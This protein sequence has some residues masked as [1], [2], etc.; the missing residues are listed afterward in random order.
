MILFPFLLLLSSMHTISGQDDDDLDN[1][2]LK[3]PPSRVTLS[4]WQYC[5]GCRG[6]IELFTTLATNKIA[7]MQSNGVSSGEE[8]DVAP[9]LDTIC[10]LSYYE[11][12]APF[13]KYGCLKLLHDHQREFLDAF[14]GEVVSTQFSVSRGNIFSKT[15]EVCLNVAKACPSSM[16]ASIPPKERTECRGCMIIMDDL[17]LMKKVL[18]LHH[19]YG[20]QEINR[21]LVDSL[22][23]SLGYNHQPYS[24]LEEI[25]DELLDDEHVGGI[26]KILNMRDQMYLNSKIHPKQTLA[27]RV[28]EEVFS[29]DSDTDSHSEL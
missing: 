17:E 5:A 1:V 26:L 6:T 28:C 4:K 9:L 10:D 8:M 25:C 13:M 2:D 18:P 22:C 12:Y 19:R 24:W 16:F 20:D 27:E 14:N 29:C 3:N 21:Q 23:N 15:K 11:R 7:E